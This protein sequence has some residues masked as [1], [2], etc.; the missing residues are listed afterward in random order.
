MRIVPFKQV[1]VFTALPFGGNPVA[2]VLD[3][4]SLEP[5]EMQHIAAWTNLSETAFVLPPIAATASYRV[6]I[7]TPRQELQFAGHPSVGTAHAVI[8]AGYA[9]P[10]NGVLVQECGAGLLPI[11]VEGEGPL[12][13]I[14]VA[15]PPA[16][17]DEPDLTM[18]VALARALG[19][20]INADPPP[21][22]IA[23]GPNWAVVDLERAEIVRK[24]KPDMAKLTELS[25]DYGVIGAAVFGRTG[26][27]DFAIAVRCF[28]P[29]DGIPEDPVTG[30]GNAAIAAF[31]RASGQIPAEGA[32]YAA[33]Q[34][35]ELGR[36][37]IVHLRVEADGTI[38]IGG[39][40]VTCVDGT[41][42][43]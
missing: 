24:L 38:H 13:R 34:G 8:E 11:E 39:R 19:A 26:R 37:G 32:R 5:S 43:L 1:D 12:R 15:T 21:R 30:S 22:A 17:I 29:V 27:D 28:A 10:K 6:R 23:V 40:S 16:Q 41:I 4:E 36:D 14:H 31:L 20:T 2:V 25:R 33:S 9:T 35:R 18:T 7:F 3:A 42:R